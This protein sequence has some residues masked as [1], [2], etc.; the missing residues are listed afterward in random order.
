MKHFTNL[1]VVA[2][3][4]TFAALAAPTSWAGDEDEIPF[5]VGKLFFQ[6]N[7]TDGD[8]GFHMKLDGEP[9]KRAKVEDPRGRTILY[10]LPRGRLR[11]QG[12]T[13]L[14]FE[15]A[16]PGFDELSP[17]E[18]FA[19]FPAGE[20]EIEGRTLTNEER[21]NEI[22]ITHVLPAPPQ[23]FKVNRMPV[24]ATSCED[25]AVVPEV[26]DGPVV[27][28]WDEVMTSHPTIGKSGPIEVTRYEVAVEAEDTE[29]K[30]EVTLPPET[31]SFTVPAGFI[32]LGD[33]FKFQVLVSDAGGNET[34]S[35]SCFEKAG[36]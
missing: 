20:Y 10:L 22:M 1:S 19:R 35:E 24:E 14:A 23:G 28:R 7:D 6:L 30:L 5:D 18:F 17:A 3:A 12:L 33:L 29:Y 2:V 25:L 11:K 15:S 32:G 8:L 26:T 27:L 31:T 36:D 4:T 13:E 21:E 16:E 9:W 34:S